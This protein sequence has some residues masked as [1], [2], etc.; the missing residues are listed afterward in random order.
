[1][2]PR[3]PKARRAARRASSG[4]MPRAMLASTSISTCRRISS[5]MSLS[6]ASRPRNARRR[7]ER[8]L[9]HFICVCPS[10]SLPHLGDGQHQAIPARLFGFELFAPGPR[11]LVELGAAPGLVRIPVGS[12][13]ALLLDAVERRVE[14]ALLDVEHLVRHL[15]DALDDAIAM[16]RP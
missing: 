7:S 5:S 13:P 12:H 14:R 6:N 4:A 3:L 1:M 8:I 2:T 11:Q 10:G 9:N 15:A 16:Q